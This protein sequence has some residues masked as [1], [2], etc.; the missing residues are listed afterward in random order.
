MPPPIIPG[1]RTDRTGTG[2][3]LRRSVAD[4]RRRYKGAQAG[5]FEAFGRIQSY[6]VNEVSEADFAV[7]YAMTPQQMAALSQ[8]LAAIMARWL[9]EGRDS[10]PG[11]WWSPYDTDASLLG[12]AQ[13]VANLTAISS[14]YAATRSI[15]GVI[16]SEPYRLRVATAQQ[17]SM[18]HWT[19]LSQSLRGDLS[20]IIGRGVADGL[21]P[22][23]VRSQIVARMGVSRSRAE[24]YAQTDIT[25]VL[26]Q[27]RWAEA[28]YA[29]D[30]MGIKLGLLWTSA[31]L[32]TTRP[33]HA[34]RHGKVYSTEEVRA[35]YATGG[36]RFRCHCSSTECLLDDDGKPMLIPSLKQAMAGEKSAWDK[37]Q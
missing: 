23:V 25:G 14:A 29:R 34:S 2:Q 24:L 27:S 37:T 32:A 7:R 5:I 4:I 12:A 13:S 18:D 36:A 8:E 30:Q 35:F 19:G 31:L 20:G 22:R 9:E 1:N 16:N 10:A 26:R 17:M 6:R 28:D 33:N 3:I 15:G 11:F 21:N